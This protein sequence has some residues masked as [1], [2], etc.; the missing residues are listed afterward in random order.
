MNT[1]HSNTQTLH[2]WLRD[3]VKPGEKRTPILP[4]H[5]AR[6]LAAGHL[7]SVEQ[8]K[9]RCVPDEEYSKVGCSLV[10]TGSWTEAPKETVILGLKE[11]P[12]S[13]SALHHRHIFFAHAYKEQE[14]WR[15]LLNRFVKGNGSVWDL[16]YLNEANGRR[17]AAFGRCAGFIGMAVGV[18]NWCH[19]I[20]HPEQEKLPTLRYHNNFKDLVAYVKPTLEE[21]IAKAGRRPEVL[22]VG[23]LG[24]CGNGAVSFAEQVGLTPIKW[25]MNET[26]V[27]GP[28]KKF[29]EVDILVNCIYLMGNIPS[30]LTMGFIKQHEDERNLSVLVDVSCDPNNPANPLPV[31]N[32]VTTFFDPNLRVIKGDKP[33]DVIAID[34]LPSL[35]PF[36]SS[37]EFADA[38]ISHLVEC[39]QTDVWTRAHN[40]FVTKST[41]AAKELAKAH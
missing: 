5:A 33:L 36:E 18:I 4:E 11:L 30:F 10:P 27:G 28:F 40:I 9:T 37:Q 6:L 35:V 15:Q 25:D 14:G 39:G 8:S 41:Q 20:L 26:A 21:A 32:K 13:D 1:Q 31:Y 34:H 7:V 17:V 19:Q 2:F 3:E 23:A 29:I 38:L 24:R 22:V 12:D 16:E